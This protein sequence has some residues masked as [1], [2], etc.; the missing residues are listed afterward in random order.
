MVMALHTG[1]WTAE[2]VRGLPDDGN[3]HECV[4]GVLL[5]TPAP[6]WLHQWAL[7]ALQ[8]RL[9][10]YVR[11]TGCGVLVRSPA[12]VR[13]GI[14]TLVQPDLF[15]VPSVEG[16]RPSGE[17]DVGRL[18]LAV[19]VLSARTAA[20][21]RG[22]KRRL[23]QACADEYWIVDL[24]A[25]IVERWRPGDARPEIA[26]VALIWQPAGTSQPLR[27][28]VAEMFREVREG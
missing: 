11:G 1:P 5:V 25:G 20:R 18:V 24:D 21:D 6:S 16:R 27:I 2:M 13:L 10:P 23:Y 26:D 3:R 7:D 28:D 8:E 22:E 14:R 15:V 4:D 17:N 12:D 9:A 19:E